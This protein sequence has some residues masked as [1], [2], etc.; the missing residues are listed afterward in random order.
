MGGPMTQGTFTF[1]PL[2]P[3]YTLLNLRAGLSRSGWEAAVF[4]NNVTNERALLAL[5]RERGLRARVGYLVNQPR[6]VGVS[7][8]FNY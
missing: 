4:V 1:N 3:A 5:D 8:N 7:L 2:L 6:T